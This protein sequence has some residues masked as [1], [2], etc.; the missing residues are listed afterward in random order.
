[1]D[2]YISVNNSNRYV[3]Y[4]IVIFSVGLSFFLLF[5][6]S[7]RTPSDNLYRQAFYLNAAAFKNGIHLA[8]I[9]FFA[10]NPNND[11]IDRWQ[12]PDVGLD[13]NNRGYPI[14]TQLSEL[15][16]K[17]ITDIEQCRQIW[18]FVLG[19]LQPKIFLN[20]NSNGYWVELIET[21][22]CIYHPFN[23]PELSLRYLASTG[24]TNLSE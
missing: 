9:K 15:D 18:Q 19:P 24:E 12:L 4:L 10:N 21:D 23:Q 3:N 13:Y 5:K 11:T 6:L 16:E 14:G 2:N 17:R 7:D 1:M 22:I 8:N 20:A